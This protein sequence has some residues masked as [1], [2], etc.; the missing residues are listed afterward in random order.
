MH[1]TRGHGLSCHRIFL[2][3]R[4]M[5]PLRKFLRKGEN[6][7]ISSSSNPVPSKVKKFRVGDLVPEALAPLKNV[8]ASMMVFQKS[9]DNNTPTLLLYWHKIIFEL[10]KPCF[11]ELEKAQTCFT[12]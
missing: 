8:K 11:R 10:N 6:I 9:K 7:E 3:G 2:E 4:G 12:F 5:F 1:R